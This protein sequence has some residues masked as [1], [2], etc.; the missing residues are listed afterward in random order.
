MP[1][2]DILEKNKYVV[3]DGKISCGKGFV[4][5]VYVFSFGQDLMI[6]CIYDINVLC[7]YRS[8]EEGFMVCGLK[9]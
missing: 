5:Q 4:E 1:F 8:S 9:W 2:K 7:I 3:M 6:N